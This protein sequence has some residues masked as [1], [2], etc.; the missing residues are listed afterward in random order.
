[1]G[2]T[3]E[4]QVARRR[5]GQETRRA[6]QQAALE[7]FTRQ[8]YASTS[9]RQ[10]AEVLGINKASL[11][12]HFRSKEDILASLFDERGSEAEDLVAW[13]REQ[14]DAPGLLESAVLRWV[15]AY[16]A[17]KLRGIRFLA[18]NPLLRAADL[19]GGDRVGAGLTELVQ[20]LAPLL[21]SPTGSHLVLLRMAVLSINAAVEAAAGTDISDDEIVTAARQSARLLVRE[22][23][24]G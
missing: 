24:R 18:A 4:Q 3:E 2:G 5:D 16:S 17:D 13:L 21:P 6:A 12:Y 15:D 7:L 14:P 22:L 10:I 11:Y 19:P 20:V 8:G 23:A 9:L 1:V